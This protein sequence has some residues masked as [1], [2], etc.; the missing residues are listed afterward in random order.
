MNFSLDIKKQIRRYLPI[1]FRKET[2]IDWLTV[3]MTPV[4]VLK[5]EFDQFVTET[6]EDMKWSGQIISLEKLLNERYGGGISIESVS[7]EIK[8]FY[9]FAP[10]DPKNDFSYAPGDDRNKISYAPGAYDFSTVDFVVKVPLALVYDAEEMSAVIR[11]NKL[12]T[13]KFRIEEV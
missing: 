1:A 6:R 11:A 9:A 10:G 5:G 13:M 4:K 2:F 7:N 3:L 12:Y 8:P